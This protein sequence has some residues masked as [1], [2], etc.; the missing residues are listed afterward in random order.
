[1]DDFEAKQELAKTSLAIQEGR[2]ELEMLESSKEEFIK[3]RTKEVNEA[4]YKTLEDA[5]IVLEETKQA[6]KE[7][8][9]IRIMAEECLQS[10]KD[11]RKAAKDAKEA[12]EEEINELLEAIERDRNEL[13]VAKN[14]LA[15]ERTRQEASLTGINSL[16]Q[17]IEREKSSLKNERHKLAV[18]NKVWQRQNE[19]KTE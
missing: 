1:M 6:I 17:T 8:E 4:V 16:L 18:A 9:D 15:I 10:A 12:G 7:T 19:I 5:K 14:D 13:N 3:Q 11:L 2:R